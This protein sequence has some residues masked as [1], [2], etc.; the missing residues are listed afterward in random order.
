MES[1][2]DNAKNA[3]LF[4]ETR[5]EFIID[6]A[7]MSEKLTRGRTLIYESQA[8][9][10]LAHCLNNEI[11]VLQKQTNVIIHDDIAD[12][13][14][15]F[16]ITFNKH[17][18]MYDHVYLESVLGKIADPLDKKMFNSARNFLIDLAFYER[19]FCSDGDV[20]DAIMREYVNDFDTDPICRESAFLQFLF[21]E[22]ALSIYDIYPESY[23][24]SRHASVYN[25]LKAEYRDI[26]RGTHKYS[27][28]SYLEIC[29]ATLDYV[30]KNNLHINRC[31]NCGKYFI[32]QSR[33]DEIYC[34]YTSPQNPDKTCKQ[35]GTTQR[36][37]EV[38]ADDPALKL[39][40]NIYTAKQM[41]VRRN[42]D[43]QAYTNNFDRFKGESA[44]W[45]RKYKSG[46]CTADE[47][48]SWL[49]EQKGKK[50]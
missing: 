35:Y 43:I 17:D 44:E 29:I 47:F 42:P 21:P 33:A 6:P 24:G 48:I 25:S 8:G 14:V 23:S 41:L 4:P 45:K 19:I 49:N 11:E 10:C 36:W 40:R 46:E 39:C 28:S 38:L 5:C 13:L 12:I 32:P 34:D 2:A 37:Y 15:N 50:T 30:I 27:V 31:K 7:T 3:V 1:R 16:G 9:S 26:V 18:H 20:E 22:H